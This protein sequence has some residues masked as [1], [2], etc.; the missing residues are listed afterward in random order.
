MLLLSSKRIHA[1]L[2]SATMELEISQGRKGRGPSEHRTAASEE[3]R[4]DSLL[5]CVGALGTEL[6]MLVASGTTLRGARIDVMVAD[7]WLIYDI[8]D[9]DLRDLPDRAA[10]A[11]VSALLADLGGVEP[12][13]LVARWHTI[14]RPLTQLVCAMPADA[15]ASLNDL[16]RR[17]RL[18][19]GNM[20]GEFVSAFNSHRGEFDSA[21]TALAVMRPYGTQI[22]VVANGVLA[23][24]HHE[25]GSPILDRL[26]TLCESLLRRAGYEFDPSMR[27]LADARDLELCAPW[28]SVQP[29]S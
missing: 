22:G 2:G 26:T 15:V 12:G 27:Y 21:P 16:V 6:D 13:S 10:A 24:L 4:F 7:A 23:A 17:H 18:R 8:L 1:L 14:A 28:C 29:V 25:G 20:Q 9:I 19:W 5:A 3:S 11:T